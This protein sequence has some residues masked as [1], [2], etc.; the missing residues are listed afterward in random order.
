MI[1]DQ[2]VNKAFVGVYL[3]DNTFDGAQLATTSEPTKFKKRMVKWVLG[4][5]WVSI[6]ELKQKELEKKNLKK[7]G[8]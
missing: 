1:V 2:K 3:I 6:K 7:D 4:W 5:T 8:N